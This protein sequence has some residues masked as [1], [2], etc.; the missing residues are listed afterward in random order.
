MKKISRMVSLVLA[1]VVAVSC[2]V[3]PA[4]AADTTTPFTTGIGGYERNLCIV[5]TDA[6]G[7]PV[8]SPRS[9]PFDHDMSITLRPGERITVYDEDMMY[10]AL[11]SNTAI[12]Y[13]V[14]LASAG[15]MDVGYGVQNGSEYVMREHTSA[16]TNISGSYRTQHSGNIYFIFENIA[17]YNI[18]VTHIRID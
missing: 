18:T 6:N 14:T 9:L 11:P 4:S 5:V 17:G 8:G 10:F 1:V 16:T 13:S 3:L 15:K 12:S 7:N 2:F